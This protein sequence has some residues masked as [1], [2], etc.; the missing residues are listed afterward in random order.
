MTM[1]PEHV[2]RVKNSWAL[3]TQ[4]AE[5][6]ANVLY[7][8]IFEL[9]PPLRPLFAGDHHE[10]KRKI[11]HMIDTMVNSLDRVEASF[12]GVEQ[13][14]ARHAHYGVKH[15]DYDVLGA[16]ILWTLAI[17]LGQ[18]FTVEVKEAWT[19][20]YNELT[21]AMKAAAA[22]TRLTH[23]VPLARMGFA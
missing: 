7:N 11:M 18:D 1:T 10:Q 20:T 8:R 3:L 2:V 21:R 12:P 13:L 16:A 4:N 6:A 15:Q 17:E 22:D 23:T 14:G 19:I 5:K 9:E